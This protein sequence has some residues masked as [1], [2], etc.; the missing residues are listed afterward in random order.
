VSEGKLHT[1]FGKKTKKKTGGG[2]DLQGGCS[3]NMARGNSENGLGDKKSPKKF[4]CMKWA[5]ERDMSGRVQISGRGDPTRWMV[6]VN[7]AAGWGGV[8]CW[9][10][11]GKEPDQWNN[12]LNK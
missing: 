5:G 11:D 12:T 2:R 7:E 6:L 3:T 1:N 10:W 9:F 4:C 8:T